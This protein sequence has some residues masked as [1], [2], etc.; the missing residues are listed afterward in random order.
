MFTKIFDSAIIHRSKTVFH[1]S[2]ALNVMGCMDKIVICLV[3]IRIAKS[4]RI[5]IFGVCCFL[6]I[7]L[8]QIDE[9]LF[10]FR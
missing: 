4:I 6:Q 8:I 10:A 1:K 2:N 7:T 5:N 3:L 9:I